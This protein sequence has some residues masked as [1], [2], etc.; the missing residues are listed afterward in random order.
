MKLKA[1]RERWQINCMSAGCEGCLTPHY[2]ENDHISYRVN[3][4]PV[5]R[6]QYE[7]AL[8]IHMSQGGLLVTPDE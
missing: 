4:T 6:M 5:D 7:T 3:D 2:K 1:W 8:R